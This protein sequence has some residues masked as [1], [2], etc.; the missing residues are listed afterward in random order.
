LVASVARE[1]SVELEVLAELAEATGLTTPRIAEVLRIAIGLL[2][3]G[4]GA[5]RGVIRLRSA[6]PAPS[7]AL[8]GKAGI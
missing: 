6:A 5:A 1:E 2:R 8:A 7:K 4:L 3:T